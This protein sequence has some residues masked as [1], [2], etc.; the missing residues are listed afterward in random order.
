MH[1]LRCVK[2]SLFTLYGAIVLPQ[3]APLQ[4]VLRSPRKG[5]PRL[6][7]RKSPLNLPLISPADALALARPQL[8]PLSRPSHAGN[9][10]ARTPG[11]KSC[12]D[13]CLTAGASPIN[14]AVVN[15]AGAELRQT[16]TLLIR[17]S[18]KG[19]LAPVFPCVIA[20]F[21]D[22]RGKVNVPRH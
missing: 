6:T 4:S 15:S 1:T 22:E 5:D 2:A 13:V 10:H 19:G 20:T 16:R 14:Y 12:L 17:G 8:Q 9:L 21:L 7:S 11:R 18:W 3:L